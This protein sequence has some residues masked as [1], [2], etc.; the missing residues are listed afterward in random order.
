LKFIFYYNKNIRAFCQEKFWPRK[1]LVF[2]MGNG[3][4]ISKKEVDAEVSARQEEL[5]NANFENWHGPN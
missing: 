4:I 2:P 3:S 1:G 5:K